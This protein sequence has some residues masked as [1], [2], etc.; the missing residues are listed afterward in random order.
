MVEI[1][2][3]SFTHSSLIINI[4]LIA[5]FILNLIFAFVIIFMERRSAG[6][7]WAWLLVLVFLP[8]IGFILYLL[9]GRQIQRNRIF[10]LKKEDRKGLAMIVDEQIEA[11]ESDDFSKGNHQIVKF[12]EMVRMLLFNNAAFLTTDNQIK[13]YTDGHAKFD[14]LLSDIKN[15][16]DYIHIQYYIFKSDE[17]GHRILSA[18]EDKLDEGLEVKM[19]YDDMG[20]RTLRK[21][22][23][24]HFR[25]KG[26]HV[27]SFFP[28]K[29]PL[30]NL[31][32][33]NRNHRKI[34]IIDG[35]IGYVGGFN[36]G[37]EY[38]GKDKKFGYWRDTHLRLEGDSVNALELRFILDW[39]S[40]S[41]RDS[42]EYEDRYF[43]DVDSGGTIGVQ[44][45]SSGPDEDWEQIKYGYLKMISSAKQSIYIQSPYFIPDQAFI[46]AI[47]IAALGGVEVNIMIPNK[48]DHPFVYWATLKNAAS[49]LSA[50]VKIYH[51]D[52]GFLHSKTLIIDDEIASVGTANMDNRSFTLNFEVNAFIYD[53]AI[54][55]QLKEAFIQDMKVSYRL[56]EDLYNKRSLWIKFKEGISQLLSPIL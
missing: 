31:R 45:A 37:D 10:K 24:K 52:N 18:L 56:T 41:N 47:K 38:L 9:L 2:S 49:L 26:G 23:L 15:A 29:L 40:Q 19:L 53:E 32:M 3:M 4:I 20:S 48:P 33:N 12:K 43:P 25:Q 44:I 46:D 13:I 8:I 6:S 39:N 28:S 30:I 1:Y 21:K 22:D 5:A 55:A 34:V 14:A 11:L 42:I 27:E 36:V 51:Y 35:K 17:L 7:I 54:A 16:K 50:G